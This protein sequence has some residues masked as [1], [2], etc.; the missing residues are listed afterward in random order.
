M[1]HIKCGIFLS[2]FVLLQS[3][4]ELSPERIQEEAINTY[5][6][7]VKWLAI[8]MP[9]YNTERL[10]TVPISISVHIDISNTQDSLNLWMGNMEG[11]NIGGYLYMVHQKDTFRFNNRFHRAFEKGTWV[12]HSLDYFSEMDYQNL[13]FNRFLDR[14]KESK[15]DYK[16]Y[17]A[18]FFRTAEFYV[19]ADTASSK[20]Y[21]KELYG[22]SSVRVGYLKG[23]FRV[24]NTVPRIILIMED[25]DDYISNDSFSD[26]IILYPG[27]TYFQP[28]RCYRDDSK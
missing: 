7:E 18:D 24:K 22:E 12:V 4:C 20:K 5:N 28:R 16:N 27:F 17:L 13:D 10:D 11:R 23:W 3:S 26:Y 6:V 21:I 8:G 14:M 15:K 19:A 9:Q 1:K 25:Q 2:L